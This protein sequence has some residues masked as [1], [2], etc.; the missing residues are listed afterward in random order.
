MD[1]ISISLLKIFAQNLH[2]AH[3]VM[4]IDPLSQ[5]SVFQ[6]ALVFAIRCKL[7]ELLYYLHVTLYYS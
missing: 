1:T 7:I 6:I 5:C 3:V 2:S 4:V